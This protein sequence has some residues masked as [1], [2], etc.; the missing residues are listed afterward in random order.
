MVSIVFKCTF[1]VY[2]RHCFRTFSR[3]QWKHSLPSSP[4]PSKTLATSH[5]VPVLW[6]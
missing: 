5:L 1:A 4:L 3:P 6:V 2:V